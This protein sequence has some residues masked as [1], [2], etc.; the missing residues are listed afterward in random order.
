MRSDFID[1]VINGIIPSNILLNKEFCNKNTKLTCIDG[2]QRLTTLKMFHNNEIPY[3][4][5]DQDTEIET[6]VYFD[7]IPNESKYDDIEYAVLDKKYIWCKFLDRKVPV[8]YYTELSYDQ[9][10]DIFQRIN[11]SMP[12]TKGEIFTS[13]FSNKNVGETLYDFMKK[14]NFMKCKRWGHVDYILYLMYMIHI[15]DVKLMKD[16]KSIRE[17]I[18]I[19]KLND[20]EKVKELIGESEEFIEIYYSN[21]ILLSDDIK[22]LSLLKWFKVSIGFMIYKKFDDYDENSDVII[23]IIKKTWKKWDN[24]EN[25]HRSCSS[26]KSIK[27]LQNVFNKIVKKMTNKK[28]GKCIKNKGKKLKKMKVVKKKIES[29]SNKKKSIGSKTKK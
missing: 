16:S 8:A 1:S 20:L 11:K 14:H 6:H 10:T 2:K 21:D 27:I 23:N 13:K 19:K 7:K 4:Q 17:N 5:I 15:D 25:K 18:F 22:Q 29:H 28:E 24:E 26:D 3:I 9:Q 12:A